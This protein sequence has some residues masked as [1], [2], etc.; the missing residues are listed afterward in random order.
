M[1][2]DVM[3]KC[4]KCNV[5]FFKNEEHRAECPKCGDTW[6]IWST[7]PYKVRG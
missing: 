1:P 2:N 3:K 5:E 4:K 6:R 7:V